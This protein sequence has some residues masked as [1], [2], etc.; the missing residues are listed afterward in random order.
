M[1]P[2]SILRA[3]IRSYRFPAPSVSCSCTSMVM[4][5]GA[6]GSA[7]CG[8]LVVVSAEMISGEGHDGVIGRMTELSKGEEG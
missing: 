8:L 2:T 7:A 5:Y 6:T 3:Y 4:L 1:L